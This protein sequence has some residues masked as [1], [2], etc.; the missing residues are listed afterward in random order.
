MLLGV[1]YRLCLVT[2]F[3]LKN[4]NHSIMSDPE[5]KVDAI[6][7]KF[8]QD[9]EAVSQNL[10]PFL[11]TKLDALSASQKDDE[12]AVPYALGAYA[13]SSMLF[14]YLRSE[15]KDTSIV[16]PELQRVKEHMDSLTKR[17][18]QP[19]EEEPLKENTIT[20]ETKDE[21]HHSKPVMLGKHTRFDDLPKEK[22]KKSKKSKKK[23]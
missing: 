9:I 18:S 14:A 1:I 6:L 5:A 10:K 11:N 21:K 4:T 15:G 3:S 20:E 2:N 12:K 13:L 22:K 8:E 19:K 17:L 23:E 7:S 16:V